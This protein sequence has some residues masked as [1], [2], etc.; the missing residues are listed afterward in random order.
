MQNFYLAEGEKNGIGTQQSH[1]RYE[2]L[3]NRLNDSETMEMDDVRDALD[4]VTKDN[5]AEF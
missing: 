4:S 3:V 1:E 5:F 2:I